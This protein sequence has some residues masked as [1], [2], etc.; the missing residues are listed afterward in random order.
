MFKPQATSGVYHCNAQLVLR[1]ATRKYYRKRDAAE[2]AT[3]QKF[4]R[5]HR[6]R[7]L[8]TI[9]QVRGKLC[10]ITSE[11]ASDGIATALHY[12]DAGFHRARKARFQY[13]SVSDPLLLLLL[14]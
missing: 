14:L 6:R 9:T 4:S 7:N 1:P 10:T 12:I 3:P 8:C 2:E 5:S 11:K 13:H